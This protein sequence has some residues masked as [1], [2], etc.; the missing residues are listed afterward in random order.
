MNGK[1]NKQTNNATNNVH[2]ALQ[3]TRTT[4]KFIFLN[5]TIQEFIMITLVYGLLVY[6]YI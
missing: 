5:V 4:E 1:T 3:F 2:D 6:I